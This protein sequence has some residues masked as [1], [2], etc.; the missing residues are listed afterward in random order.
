MTP[1]E[2]IQKAEDEISAI[3][4]TNVMPFQRSLDSKRRV[5]KLATATVVTLRANDAERERAAEDTRIDRELYTKLVLALRS[6]YAVR[7]VGTDYS[8]LMISKALLEAGKARCG[9][10]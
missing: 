1:H 7:G 10:D 6:V 8:K 5:Q 3:K 4:G 9:N 2:L